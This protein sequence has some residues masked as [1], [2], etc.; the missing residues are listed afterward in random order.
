MGA[1]TGNI[2]AE[3]AVGRSC[4]GMVGGGGPELPGSPVG[5]SDVK[6]GWITAKGTEDKTANVKKKHTIE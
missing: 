5:C 6:P 1:E 2:G 3:L 4:S